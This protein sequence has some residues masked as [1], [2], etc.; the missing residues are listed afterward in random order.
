[1]NARVAVR[2]K[3]AGGAR[4]PSRPV[5]RRPGP[6]P[7][8]EA[9]AQRPLAGEAGLPELAQTEP[10]AE[11]PG[12]ELAAAPYTFGAI[13][14]F[15]PA[16]EAEAPAET[17]EMLAEEAE[18]PTIDVIAEPIEA[19][20]AGA[21]V[22]AIETPATEAV[23]EPGEAPAIGAG[24]EAG[25]SL[26]H[27]S[28]TS[29]PLG[30]RPSRPPGGV[31]GP[32]RPRSQ[33]IAEQP[34]LPSTSAEPAE[35]LEAVPVRD[36]QGAVVGD[37]QVELAESDDAVLAEE[38][39]AAEVAAEPL[40]ALDG[41]VAEPGG[42]LPHRSALEMKLGR[43]L[44]DVRVHSGDASRE[45][46]DG[47]GAEAATL[48]Q[49][50]FLAEP[51]P[52]LDIVAH[53]VVHALQA[54]SG[55]GT[56]RATG[57]V[58]TE[59]DPAEREAEQLTQQ[60]L[61]RGAA[62]RKREPAEQVPTGSVALLRTGSA[63]SA[64]PPGSAAT[65]S[66]AFAAATGAAGAKPPSTRPPSTAPGG[67]T[68]PAR[69]P[70]TAPAS[71]APAGVG[72]TA[73]EA[74]PA[75][76]LPAPPPPGLTP[77]DVA[78]QQQKA[79][80]AEAALS[81]AENVTGLMGAFAGAPPTVMAQHAGALGSD[82][83]RLAKS[84]EASF[85]ESLPE[86]HAEL[87]G[88]V[89]SAET[90][91]IPAPAARDVTL[92][93][94]TPP[95]APLPE[96][97][98]TVD[99]GAYT[100]ND[101]LARELL[102]HL[103]GEPGERA[104]EVGQAL[105]DVQ[106]TDPEI[107]TSAGPPP[108]V[109][110]EGESDP[111]RIEQQ[112]SEGIAQ[113]KAARGEAQQAVLDGPGPELVQPRVMDEAYPVGELAAPALKPLPPL[114][115]PEAY[116]AMGMTPDVQ[117]A[118][119]Q[120]QQAAMQASLEGP[121]A[122]IEA[123]GTERDTKREAEVT[124]AESD[125]Q[126][127]TVEADA[128]QRTQVQESRELIQQERGATLEAQQQAVA[129]A[130]SSVE[131]ERKL[132]KGEI[133]D[134]VT[135]DE[136]QIRDHYE[137][138]D[139][140]AKDEVRKGEAKAE[141][142]RRAAE[143]DA[144]EESWWDRAVSFVKDAF[145]ALTSAIGA[146]FDAVRSAVNS[147]LDAVKTFALELIDA[148]AGFIKGAIALF[149]E[150]LKAAVDALLGEIFPELAAALKEKIDGAVT[151]AQ[152]AV[153]VVADGLK[154]GVSAIV[155]GLKA[156]LNA[157]I[158]IYQAAVELGLSLVEAAIT[159][160]WSGL[161]RKLLEAALKVAGISPEEFYA[162]IGR[163]EETFQLILDDPGQFLGNCVDAVVGGVQK[164]ADDFLTHLQT[165]VIEWLTGAI[166]GAG[167]TLPQ[168]FDL[169]GVLDLARQ[170]LGLT[171][172]HLRARAVKLIGEKNVERI[173]YVADYLK[174]LIV[175]GWTALL[176]QITESLS[177]L[178]DM[179]MESLKGYLLEKIVIA[180]ITRLA[181][182]FNPVGALVQLV[183][184]AW[185]LFTF[186]RDQLSRI[187]EVLKTIVG[188]IVDIARGVIDPASKKVEGVL[189]RLL[190]LALDLLARF[191][192]LTG[193]S[194]KV[195]E[196]IEG[197]RERVNKAI[198][199]LIEK[200]MGLFKGKGAA[201][202]AAPPAKPAA[203]QQPPD[204]K[205]DDQKPDDKKADDVSV[206]KS[207]VAPSVVRLAEP[208]L[209]LSEEIAQAK[210]ETVIYQ[211]GG[212][213]VD[214]TRK[215]LKENPE[216]RFDQK[217]GRL[218]LPDVNAKRLAT[219]DSLTG[220]GKVLGE[221]LDVTRLVL[222]KTERGFEIDA[223]I[224]PTTPTVTGTE[225]EHRSVVGIR[226]AD[227]KVIQ[228]ASF[229][230]S[231]EEAL[232]YFRSLQLGSKNITSDNLR[233]NR[234]Y[235]LA[236]IQ[237]SG[238]TMGGTQ[239]V[240][241]YPLGP[242]GVFTVFSSGQGKPGVSEG[243]DIKV[244]IE[245]ARSDPPPKPGDP[246]AP[247]NVIRKPDP[248]LDVS[249]FFAPPKILVSNPA[250]LK[251]FI[252]KLAPL[253]EV[254]RKYDF[255][256]HRHSEQV[257]WQLI[258]LEDN[259]KAI[260]KWIIDTGL[261][262]INHF[263]VNIHSEREMCR[264]CA[265]A[266]NFMLAQMES[267]LPY[268]WEALLKMRANAQ[269]PLF[270]PQTAVTAH[271]PFPPH[272]PRL[273]GPDKPAPEAAGILVDPHGRPIGQ[274]PTIIGT[275]P[276]PAIPVGEAASTVQAGEASG[277]QRPSTTLSEEQRAANVQ[278]LVQ[279]PKRESGKVT[280]G[281]VTTMGPNPVYPPPP[282]QQLEGAKATSPVTT[283][284]ASGEKKPA[285]PTAEEKA[286]GTSTAAQPKAAETPLPQQ[287]K[288]ESPTPATTQGAAKPVPPSQSPTSAPEVTPQ[289]AQAPS[290]AQQVQPVTVPNPAPKPVSPTSTQPV[291]DPT[292]AAKQPAPSPVSAPKPVPATVPGPAPEPELHE[293]VPSGKTTKSAPTEATSTAKPKAT[294]ASAPPEPSTADSGAKGGA[295][296]T[297]T[298]GTGTKGSASTEVP[299]GEKTAT[300][301]GLAKPGSTPDE[302]T[303]TAKKP[304]SPPTADS[305]A[306]AAKPGAKSVAVSTPESPEP[307]ATTGGKKP[308][309]KAVAKAPTP[310]ATTAE[311]ETPAPPAK[312]KAAPVAS[313]KAET[314]KAA[315]TKASTSKTSAAKKAP[316]K[317]ATVKKTPPKKKS[318]T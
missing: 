260:A 100:A 199:K 206:P 112:Q 251:L 25:D 233:G 77:E 285:A 88:E 257:V 129:D 145:E 166:G 256:A 49:H 271:A 171:W 234:N 167:I 158:D 289:T 27:E 153:D 259:Q 118:F 227:G 133:D 52:A 82:T 247:I 198:D 151:F 278:E 18:A 1:M 210:A 272:A 117:A 39:A 218:T 102:R 128:D 221:E 122:E 223:E 62:L 316:V 224:N 228:S 240:F 115:G 252:E 120:Q 2:P 24:V 14:L 290:A 232:L 219:A 168:K 236:N 35:T 307:K 64:V 204:K 220:L 216:A 226:G 36:E 312:K 97:P 33:H 197:I 255:Q 114:E 110:L 244:G 309:T 91:E 154:A 29:S 190:P 297:S 305:E 238:I 212:S 301:K 211:A 83:D 86:L 94:T 294:M 162:F 176:E 74:A 242:S 101:G 108:A 135:D 113:A 174:T 284:P 261:R 298:P 155:D 263:V 308:S 203:A 287:A 126:A 139:K 38:P 19:P 214:V 66:A 57:A 132:R 266:S 196:I 302:S 148:V 279:P 107:A 231:L 265:A 26:G 315:T 304:A 111:E 267:E 137:Q 17:G 56:P 249:L 253:L 15:P 175:G 95:P 217:S 67:A 239:I 147:I 87:S 85:Q 45:A 169:L 89:P 275:K 22:E 70:S 254:Q 130:E 127:L 40:A 181:T 173:E 286:G 109:P 9:D 46:L 280:G 208:N 183:L 213:P 13:S 6:R 229:A 65:P 119:D 185:N 277:R 121:R 248:G 44:G 189:A 163:A 93:A 288:P 20:T 192:G 165:G 188:A 243:A 187:V 143:R 191:L 222:R 43:P 150:F 106:T 60:A 157:I 205:P 12:P 306:P 21:S 194:K 10:I 273:V 79:A 202:K 92:E 264:N 63:P 32:G 5:V 34:S 180:A 141:D 3:P 283:A 317:K 55:G 50:V 296:T 179:V 209:A 105:E 78:A 303:S 161:A 72:P 73:D 300:K 41:A 31:A 178:R 75:L 81:G 193:I 195:Q 269:A 140:D 207:L 310:K 146:I 276:A 230:G 53:E 201:G 59:S 258:R 8:V 293:L 11:A 144:E 23:V 61:D 123:A 16:E 156:G 250:E 54:E 246:V 282:E 314:T 99:P 274:G 80:E 295:K 184:A 225:V 268:I 124:K 186:L 96:L 48:G 270:L 98:P 30:A 104:G 262:E 125:V 7:T 237:V 245:E 51:S 84:E 281:T 58:V 235:A 138:A 177:G 172:E 90:V 299:P 160:D 182:L 68:P 116:L 136:Q 164:F 318:T 134:R 42:P 47:L 4:R 71:T 152:Q 103:T 142:E 311:A 131:D 215:L 291:P 313:P 76:E 149:G 170:I 292:A 241:T 200:V 159:G 69:Q 37:E 28:A